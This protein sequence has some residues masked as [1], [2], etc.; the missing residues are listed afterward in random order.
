MERR[1]LGRRPSRGLAVCCVSR[2]ADAG[3]AARGWRALED[4]DKETELQ[5]EA[6]AYQYAPPPRL[7]LVCWCWC[8][9]TGT[10]IHVPGPPHLA[11]WVN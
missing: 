5:T 2:A 1:R 7:M 6:A 10:G 8:R 4:T 3:E 9:R 11:P